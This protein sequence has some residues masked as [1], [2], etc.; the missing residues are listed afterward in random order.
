MH[1]YIRT[2]TIQSYKHPTH[3][4]NRKNLI[5]ALLS[6]AILAALGFAGCKMGGGGHSGSGMKPVTIAW[7]AVTTNS[8]A[9]P[10]GD[11]SGYRLF[12]STASFNRGGSFLSFSA[13]QSDSS[14]FRADTAAPQTQTTIELNPGTYYLRLVAFDTAGNYS[15]FNV[16]D[17]GQDTELVVTVKDD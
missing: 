14:I 17:S 16:G 15:G 12:W 3:P 13:V 5:A 8:D 11:L 2:A 4:T 9:S 10:M 7:D 6:F 1:H